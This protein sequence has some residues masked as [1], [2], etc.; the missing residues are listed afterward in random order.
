[1]IGGDDDAGHR[2][3]R[4]VEAKLYGKVGLLLVRRPAE[5]F[6]DVA[7]MVE[8]GVPVGSETLLDERDRRVGELARVPRLIASIRSSRPTTSQG[9]APRALATACLRERSCEVRAGKPHKLCRS[10]SH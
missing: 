9:T 6:K 5:G 8:A 1:V 7:E 4:D 10:W 2:H 3:A